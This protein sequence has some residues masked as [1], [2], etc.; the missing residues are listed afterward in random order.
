MAVDIAADAEYILDGVFLARAVY[1]G[2]SIASAFNVTT[3]NDRQLA[4]DYRGYVASQGS[5]V[6]KLLAAA[7]L[8]AFDG[9]GFAT[10]TAGG[11]YTAFVDTVVTNSNDAQGLLAVQGD[12]LVL[13]FRGTDG[14]DPAVETGQAFV[15]ASL[16]EHYKAFRPLINGALSY[17]A[18][19]PEVQHVVVSGHSLGGAL[20]DV[21]A[22]VDAGKF[23]TLRPGGLTMVST[24]SSGVPPDLPE[25]IKNIDETAA[26]IEDKT[27]T[28]GG[29]TIHIRKIVDLFLPPDY[30]AIANADDRVRFSE[31]HPDIPEAL[32]LIPITT[33]KD[34]LH[35]GGDLVFNNPNIKNT[36]VEY[37]SP[38]SHPLD[39]RGFGAEHNGNLYWANA[40]ALLSDPLLQRLDAQNLIAGLP[41]FTAVP[42][43]DGQP[44]RLFNGYIHR[45]EPRNDW[46]RADRSLL[47]STAAE[48]AIAM[49]GNDRIVAGSGDDLLSGDTGNDVLIGGAGADVLNGGN[50]NDKL[51]GS[52][53]KDTLIGGIGGDLFIFAETAHSRPGARRDVVEDFN[54]LQDDAIDLTAIDAV[55]GG[56]DDSFTL[57]TGPFTAH[58]QLR[59]VEIDGKTVVQGNTEGDASA[60]FEVGFAASLSLVSADFR[61]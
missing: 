11:L 8:P 17:L 39:F 24:G 35:F 56:S 58:G 7:D 16:A 28:V 41:D 45:D 6:W 44:L 1:G 19:Y 54:H 15:G 52:A 20:V 61:F 3:D 29:V 37:R 36:E 60:D 18:A 59:F 42:D 57:V 34:N 22:L 40:Q 38:L 27:I 4:D 21:F 49:S 9:K 32:G 30:V 43:W 25:F 13:S 55:A 23:R 31:D 50:G 47:G 14:E 33:L 26:T 5:A 51:S 10:F 53:G 2:T 46:D 12:T 48:F